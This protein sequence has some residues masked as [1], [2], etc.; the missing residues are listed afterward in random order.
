MRGAG[1]AITYGGGTQFESSPPLG[2]IPSFEFF[3]LDKYVKYCYEVVPVSYTGFRKLL[4]F[5]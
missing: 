1:Q 3:C 5:K 2:G 4:P